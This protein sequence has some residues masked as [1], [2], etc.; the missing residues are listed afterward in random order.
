MKKLTTLVLAL[1]MAVSSFAGC[2]KSA[3]EIVQEE[4]AAVEEAV[5]EEVQ[6]EE[7]QTVIFTD[8]LGREVELSANIDKI[9]VSGPMAQIVLFALAPDKLVGIANEWDPGAENYFDEKYFN[10]PVL[11]Q[12]YG[13][14]GE[15]NLETLLASGAQVVIDVG[16]AKDGAVEELDALQQQTGIPFVHIHADTAGM[17]NTFRILGELLGMTK[18]AEVL[19]DYCDSV[20]SRTVEIANSVEKVRLLYCLG[21]S[22][23]N[24]IA[25]DSY[26]GEIIDL[27]S[28]NI[29]VVDA[30]SSKGTGNEVDM[31]QILKWN[32]D[33]IVFS[34]ESIYDTVG[35]DETWQSVAAIAAGNYY[36]VPYGPY[37]WLGFP[38]SAQRYMGMMW[39]SQLLYPETANYDLKAEIKQYFELFYHC[40]LTD[41][42]YSAFV[43][44]SID[45]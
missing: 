44:N 19:A 34:P 13:G 2:A 24:V 17:G 23:I 7:A 9:A 4:P 1:L 3:E 15:L 45:K 25:K 42:Q 41:A 27:L 22:G 20:Y 28:D 35:E 12:L 31:E 33:V 18:E 40:E 21:D 30:P 43:A 14:K 6:S 5:I 36:E 32:P 37:N 29:A 38:P 8:S 26:H 39:L 16:E 11:G 10:L